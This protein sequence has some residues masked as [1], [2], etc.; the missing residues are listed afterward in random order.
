[1][2]IRLNTFHYLLVSYTWLDA[3]EQSIKRFCNGAERESEQ[4]EERKE[5]K[6]GKGKVRKGRRCSRI[7]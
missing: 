7:R 5:K 4:A 1:M 6:E 2:F 3:F